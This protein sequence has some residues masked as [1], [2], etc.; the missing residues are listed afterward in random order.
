MTGDSIKCTP[1]TREAITCRAGIS[2]PVKPS[3]IETSFQEL[4]ILRSGTYIVCG[5]S[6]LIV[7]IGYRW[8][9]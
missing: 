4:Q 8:L 5:H 7:T 6:F 2:S 9:I 1:H 3:S